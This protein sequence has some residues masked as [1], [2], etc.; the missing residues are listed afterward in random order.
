MNMNDMMKG[1]NKKIINPKE[2][3]ILKVVELFNIL[4]YNAMAQEIKDGKQTVVRTCEY[5][6]GCKWETENKKALYKALLKIS[7]E[8]KI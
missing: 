4:W 5:L 7:L 6:I 8:C 2:K 1:L 3:T